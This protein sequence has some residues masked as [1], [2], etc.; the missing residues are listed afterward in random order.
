V[1]LTTR[2]LV[3]LALVASSLAAAPLAGD[4]LAAQPPS[5]APALA[6]EAS[7]RATVTVLLRRPRAA[8][9]TPRPTVRPSDPARVS[10][11]YGQPHARGRKVLGGL[12]PL[13]TVWRTGANAATSLTTDV[14]LTFGGVRVPWGSYT[15]FSRASQAGSHELIVNKQTGQWGTIYD[16][17][18]DL[19]RIPLRARTLA[20]P[21]ETFTI[22]LVP[23]TQDPS[24]GVLRMAWGTIE[25]S[26]DWQAA[27]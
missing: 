18:Q 25:L 13:D 1:I 26:A 22:W 15:L 6:A 3:R 7:G 17:K 21:V 2:S 10:I 9:G 11:D 8:Q 12:I 20:E 27:P 4:A 5:T 23:S 14:D 19:V 16:A 24:R